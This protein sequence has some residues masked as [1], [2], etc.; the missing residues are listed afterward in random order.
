MFSLC[1]FVPIT[2]FIFL[3]LDKV[4]QQCLH[5][6]C[7]QSQ[8]VL[9]SILDATVFLWITSASSCK[10]TV[11]SRCPK[12]TPGGDSICCK[13]PCSSCGLN[14]THLWDTL[15]IVMDKG[16]N[17]CTAPHFSKLNCRPVLHVSV[18]CFETL[19]KQILLI[20]VLLCKR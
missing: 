11:T 4:N 13:T 14:C 6:Q 17:F 8:I 15:A 7:I 20:I 9:D 16:L 18:S 3:L 2:F 5:Q 10:P 12:R 1:I 19:S